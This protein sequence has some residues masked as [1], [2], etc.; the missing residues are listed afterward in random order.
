[1]PKNVCR[2]REIGK[3]VRPTASALLHFGPKRFESELIGGA[4]L[5]VAADRV[6]MRSGTPLTPEIWSRRQEDNHDHK[7]S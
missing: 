6:R 3:P 5:A 2:I 7:T 4:I 1:M